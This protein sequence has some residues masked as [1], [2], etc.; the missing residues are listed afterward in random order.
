M[1]GIFMS[2]MRMKS[3][4]GIHIG[5]RFSV[6]RTFSQQDAMEFAGISRDYNPAH[7][8]KRFSEAKN[9]KGKIC[10]GLLVASMITEIGGQ[11]GWL[12]TEM[13]FKFIKPVYFGE[14]IKCEMLIT[15]ISPKGSAKAEAVFK[16][17]EGTPV[18]R[19]FLKGIIPGESEKQVMRKM[20]EEGDPTNKI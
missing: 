7:F 5:D 13:N 4:E 17:E 9:F 19:A 3:I 16:N 10:H 6:S 12:A 8:D 1:I 18:L 14:M 15:D 2:S 20:I 11:V